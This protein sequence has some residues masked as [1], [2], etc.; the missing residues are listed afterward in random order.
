AELNGNAV[1]QLREDP[2]LVIANVTPQDAGLP[3]MVELGRSEE[4]EPQEIAVTRRMIELPSVEAANVELRDE[5]FAWE[6]AYAYRVVIVGSIKL[7]N[8]STV[9]FD[10]ASTPP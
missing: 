9:V 4:G 5:S 7:P 8:G 1:A 2:V 3:Q 6:K 10:G